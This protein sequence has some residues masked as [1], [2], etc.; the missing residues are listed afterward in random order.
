MP[1]SGSNN[2]EFNVGIISTAL[3][4]CFISLLSLTTPSV[5]LNK[6]VGT[7]LLVILVIVLL[8]LKWKI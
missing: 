6:L 7:P 8:L 2:A 1:I 4:A 5:T 3:C